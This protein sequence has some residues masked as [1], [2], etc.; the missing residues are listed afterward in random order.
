M[1]ISEVSKK[2]GL[3]PDTLRYYERI[4]MLPPVH[5]AANG[6]RDYDEIDCKWVEL[7]KC[8]R[9]ADLPI[10]AI[11]E[12]VRLFQQGEQTTPAR[13]E[14][15]LSQKQQLLQKREQIDRTIERLEYKI[16]RYEKQLNQGELC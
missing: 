3:S 9:S 2:Y 12:Y 5:R 6:L 15:L 14:L 7:V 4:G 1:T 16:E 13:Y 8:M 11:I 10:E